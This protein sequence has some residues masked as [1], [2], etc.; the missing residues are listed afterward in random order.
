MLYPMHLVLLELI[1]D[2]LC[3]IV[4]E[5]EPSEADAIKK[6]PR[7]SR[8]PLFGSSQIAVAAFDGFVL[9][10]CV[11]G[12]YAWLHQSGVDDGQARAASFIALVAGHLTLAPAVM[13]RSGRSPVHHSRILWLVAAGASLLLALMLVVPELRQIMRFAS[14]DAGQLLLGLAVGIAA[15][16]WSGLRAFFSRAGVPPAARAS[17]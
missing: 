9:L 11:L 5:A 16:G 12:L 10:A 8:E 1:I 17:A 13:A 14:P 7:N 15:G 6:P 3:S 4:F 2:P